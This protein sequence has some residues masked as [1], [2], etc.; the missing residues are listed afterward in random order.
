MSRLTD[1]LLP[2]IQDGMNPS[3]QGTSPNFKEPLL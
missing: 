3:F 2:T 1:D